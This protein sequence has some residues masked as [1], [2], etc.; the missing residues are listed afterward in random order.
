MPFIPTTPET[1]QVAVSTTVDK[2]VDTYYITKIVIVRE[3]NTADEII[4]R[5]QWHEGYTEDEQFYAL[6]KHDSYFN[7]AVLAAKM[8]EEVVEG[9]TIFETV[10]YA[11]WE[12]IIAEQGLDGSIE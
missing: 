2:E 4:V 6:V 11:A 7:G 8:A 12:L 9:R 1:K 5:I 10:K 3:P